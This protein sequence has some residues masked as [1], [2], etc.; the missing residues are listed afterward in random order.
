MTPQSAFMISAEI[1]PQ[2]LHDLRSLLTAMNLD[3]GVVDPENSIVP[4][5]AFER[6]H[7]AR[8]VIIEARN[9][10]DLKHNDLEPRP[11]PSTLF[12]LGDCD[13]P[14]ETFLEELVER[15]GPGLQ[16]IFSHCHNFSGEHKPLRQ[17]LFEHNIA[18][19]ANYINWVGRTVV[20]VRQ[21]A[22]LHTLLST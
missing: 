22:A 20:Q 7:F 17:W 4:F 8:F 15:A 2:R 14:Y 12:F 19:S 1:I 6:L 10:E 13:G 5:S 9:Q 3:P 11:W 21:E 18:P 16:K